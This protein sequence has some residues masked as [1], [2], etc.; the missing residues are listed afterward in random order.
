[1]V[2]R[3]FLS[4]FWVASA[5]AADELSVDAVRRGPA[6]EVRA[7]AVIDAPHAVVWDT[8]TDYNRLS[9]FIPG[10]LRS[11]VLEW[12]GNEA[13][14]EQ[15]GEAK[16]LFFS[17]PIDVTVGSASLPPD[18]IAV[19]VIRGNLRRLEGGY[20]IERADDGRVV[21]RWSGLIEPETLLPPLLGEA[22][23]R[24]NI[25]DQFTGMVRE[26]ERREAERRARGK[27]AGA[28]P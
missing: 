19:R 15:L 14:V 27:A 1:M 10:M 18:A 24:A 8:L 12:R 17:F 25:E 16:F 28:R 2:A 6:V 23:M 20:R 5:H 3:L 7:R 11:R 21:L 4:C 22:V 26:I 13:I 9:E